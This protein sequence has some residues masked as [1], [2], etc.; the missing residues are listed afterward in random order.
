MSWWIY[1]AIL[2]AFHPGFNDCIILCA[3]QLLE[4]NDF[5]LVVFECV[6]FLPGAD[7]SYPYLVIG[8]NIGRQWND[9]GP[10]HHM[11]K[12]WPFLIIEFTIGL[13]GSDPL[14]LFV[15]NQRLY[16]YF[17]SMLSYF[18]IRARLFRNIPSSFEVSMSISACSISPGKSDSNTSLKILSDRWL[19]MVT[20]M[21]N[22][23]I[24]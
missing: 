14:S 17:A 1:L 2:V 8:D 4:F 23:T 22:T 19:S 9:Q 11:S 18:S 12:I 24:K 16:R 13:P 15:L 3:T 21:Q 5:A 7:A 20:T 10:I 6:L